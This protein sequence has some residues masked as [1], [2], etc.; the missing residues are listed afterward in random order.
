MKRMPAGLALLVATVALA[1]APKPPSTEDAMVVHLAD[2]KW[3]APK[4]PG[5]PPGVMTSPVAVDP[6]SGGSV[7]YAKF[8]PG[9]VFPAHWHSATEY[10]VLI[11]GSP[12]FTVDGK[13]H[14]LLPG[15]YL[16]IPP[17]AKHDVRCGP[18]AEC[19]ILTRRAGPTDYHWVGK[20]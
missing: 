15:S 16:V 7:G 13:S 6:A 10:S 5:I 1:D 14:T 12:T 8:P 17:K 18:A 3:T 4:V 11:S 20:E 19:V 2:L 9:Y